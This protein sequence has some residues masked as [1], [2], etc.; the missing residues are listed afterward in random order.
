MMNHI[1]PFRGAFYAC[2]LCLLFSLSAGAGVTNPD[3]SVLGQMRTFMTDDPADINR[4]RAQIA[5]GETEI[6]ADTYLNPFSRGTCVFSIAEGGIEVEEG[7]LQIFRGLPRG[8]SIKA[9]KYRVGFGKLNQVHCHAYPFLTRFR[10]MEA[11][12]PGEEAFNE[13]GGQLSYLLPLP[14]DIASTLAVDI[15]QGKSFHPDEEDESRPCVVGRWSNFFLLQDPSALEIGI[16]VAQGVNN[17]EMKTTSILLGVDVKAKLWRNARDFL[18]LQA[19][20]FGLDREEATLATSGSV[21]TSHLKPSGG[22]F[23]ADYTIRKRYNVGFKFEHFQRPEP[24]DAGEK[25]W[26][27]SIGLFTGVALMEET[28]IFRLNW[29]RYL[30]DEGEAINTFTL[31][32]VFSMGPH[33]PHQF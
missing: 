21:S 17:V 10:V 11:Y 15:L 4:D 20:F 16:S 5:L 30:P 24:N 33:K 8:F 3:I 26:D 12:L 18:V 2:A 32:C 7:Y 19:E 13:T 14:G 31:Q 29:D 23:F 25:L 28:T 6:V 27:R 9:G 1:S 22:Y